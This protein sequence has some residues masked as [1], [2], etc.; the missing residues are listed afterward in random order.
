MKEKVNIVA[1]V[2][3]IG[4][5][6][7]ETLG[8]GN[9]CLVD[10]GAFDSRGQGTPELCTVVAPGQVVS[11]SAVAVDVQTPVV[12]KSITFIGAGQG[13][14]ANGDT[15]AAQP[16][17]AQPAAAQP[18]DA[19]EPAAVDDLDLDV[20]AGIVPAWLTPGVPFRYRLELKMHEGPHSVLSVDSTAL[21][22]V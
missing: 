18:A 12:I 5:L 6:S 1:V 7:D 3:V 21:M 22:S 17:A 19:S 10:D 4:A 11:W 15:A 20:W 14:S 2:D 8:N 13:T 9:L 16:A